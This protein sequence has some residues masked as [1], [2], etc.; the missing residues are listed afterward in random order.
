[1]G[2]RFFAWRPVAGD[3][4]RLSALSGLSEFSVAG[5]L[6]PP[7]SWCRD[8]LFGCVGPGT[9]YFA[10]SVLN[11]S[12]SPRSTLPYMSASSAMTGEMYS[13]VSVTACLSPSPLMR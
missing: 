13:S 5:C 9:V 6:P 7:G 1:M 2:V 12:I 10:V 8:A 11:R 3:L 4:A